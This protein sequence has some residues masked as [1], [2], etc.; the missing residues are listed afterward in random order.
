[1]LISGC[2]NALPTGVDSR[3]DLP[4]QSFNDFTEELF[5]TMVNG[6][7]ITLHYTLADPESYGIVPGDITFGS[8]TIDPDKEYWQQY[9]DC[10][11]QLHQY[12]KESLNKEERV[13]YDI[14]DAYLEQAIK[15]Q[16]FYYYY[17]PLKPGTGIHANYP[18]LM[19]EYVFYDKQDIEDYLTLFTK[20]EDFFTLIVSWEE[21]KSEE[22][23]FM[24]DALA[25]KIIEESESYLVDEE[26][27]EENFILATFIERLEQVGDLTAE[28]KKAYQERQKEVL[29]QD[30]NQAYLLLTE[31]L[32]ALKGSGK[33]DMGCAN[34]PKGKKYYE[35]LIESSIGMTYSSV[36][37]LYRTIYKEMANGYEELGTLLAEDEDLIYKWY[38]TNYDS[39]EPEEMLEDLKSSIENDFPAIK[40]SSYS[41]RKVDESMED[42]LSPAFYLVPPIDCYDENVIY[43]NDSKMD[44]ESNL[45]PVL[46]HEGYPGHLYQNAYFSANNGSNLRHMFNYLGYTEGWATY[47]KYYSVIWDDAIEDSVKELEYLNDYLNMALSALL[48]IGIHYYGWSQKETAQKLEELIGSSEEEMVE[49]IYI[50]ITGDPGAYLDYH[51]GCMEIMKLRNEAR[52][53][54]GSSYEDIAFHQFILDMGPAPFF[55]I[56]PYFE[57]WLEGSGA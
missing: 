29:L 18:Y 17:E 23:L 25:E 41:V 36:D 45:Y 20:M 26:D 32:E 56:R 3:E 43:I 37:S 24:S 33:N 44:Q 8:L 35:Y 48:D 13:T 49:E 42:F 22:G 21:K 39:R 57:E 14:L 55:V 9:E 15:E 51:V 12:T 30:F 19:A 16:E 31:G 4:Q 6:D 5:C 2:S 34:L 27:I 46:A 47:A 52:K 7:T 10:R 53:E 1:M 50:A 38:S 54:L 40:E 11:R 28:E